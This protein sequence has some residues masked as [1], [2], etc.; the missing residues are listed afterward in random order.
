MT[1]NSLGSMT[2]HRHGLGVVV[3]EGPLYAGNM[4]LYFQVNSLEE[5]KIMK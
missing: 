1:W 4:R 5:M 3:L 2:T